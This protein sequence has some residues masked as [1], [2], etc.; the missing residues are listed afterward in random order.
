MLIVDAEKRFTIDQCLAHPWLNA[1]APNVNDSTGGLVGGIAGLEVNRRAPARERTLLSSLNTVQV[2]A[3][4]EVGKNKNP[5]KV[6]SKNKTR[7]NNAPKEAGPAHHRAANEFM[8]LGGKGD[9][10]LY[11]NEDASIYPAAEGKPK[12]AGKAK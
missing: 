1:T 10:E 9:Q 11:P 4:L 12:K 8:E 5:V 6:F 2:T 7:V 3:Q